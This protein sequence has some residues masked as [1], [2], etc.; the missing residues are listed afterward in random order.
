MTTDPL[1][2]PDGANR[3]AAYH[4]MHGTVDPFGLCKKG[5]CEIKLK[6]HRTTGFG[7]QI[8][9]ALDPGDPFDFEV[10]NIQDPS[11]ALNN[12]PEK[13]FKKI[14]KKQL[15]KLA[16]RSV[17]WAIKAELMGI[18]AAQELTLG[19]AR[20]VARLKVKYKRRDCV[21]CDT[22]EWVAQQ[23]GLWFGECE[24]WKWGNWYN[25]SN[26]VQVTLGSRRLGNNSQDQ[27]NHL[28]VTGEKGVQK[29]ATSIRKL[30]RQVNRNN[31]TTQA[32]KDA[33]EEKT[34]CTVK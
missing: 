34:G 5:A 6:S 20:F 32:V 3:Y 23:S 30:W 21:C 16:G 29:V 33:L 7:L 9:R 24:T 27:T 31:V 14:I 28:V 10:G 8:T 13:V 22:I 17:I 2:Y 26:N 15:G 12:L 18:G 11:N 19:E 1:G 4:I 25:D